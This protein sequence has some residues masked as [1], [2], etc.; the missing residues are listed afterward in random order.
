MQTDTILLLDP[1]ARAGRTGH[2]MRVVDA[3][4]TRMDAREWLGNSRDDLPTVQ[5][6][7]LAARSISRL[8]EDATTGDVAELTVFI[9]GEHHRLIDVL[10]T[11]RP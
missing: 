4:R 2:R 8:L 7:L 1:T 11:F 6:L 9:G 5:A 10:K 3:K